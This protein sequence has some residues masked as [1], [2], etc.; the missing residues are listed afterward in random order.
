MKITCLVENTTQCGLPT[1]HGLSLYI[2]MAAHRILF[3]LGPD[4]TALENARTLGIDPAAVDTVILSHGHN[5][6]G[7]GLGAFLEINHTAKVYAQRRAFEPHSS[8]SGG[9]VHDI[10]VDPVLAAHPQVVLLDGDHTI[11]GELRLF[12]VGDT[13]LCRSTANDSLHG[14][15]GPDDFAHEQNLLIGGR[16]LVFGCGHA[17]IVNILRKAAVRPAVCIG[18]LHLYSPRSGKTVEHDLLHRI[19]DHLADCDTD[20]YTCHCTGPEAFAVLHG[21]LERMHYLACGDRIEIP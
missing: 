8:T 12:T 18:G 17:G 19:A 21:R 2:E 9:S 11:D 15:D 1:R 14:P 10:S 5:D 16:V 13:S 3:D 4:G 6:H 7:G 20:F